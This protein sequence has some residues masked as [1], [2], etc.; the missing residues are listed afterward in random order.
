MRIGFIGTGNMGT[1]L[2]KGVVRSGI[3]EPGNIR[4]FDVDSERAAALCRETGVELAESNKAL[5]EWADY[6][7]LAVKPN[8]VKIPL[9][10]CKSSFDASKVLISIAAG[11]AIKSIKD[12]LGTDAKVVR[13]MPNMPAFVGEGMTLVSFDDKINAAEKGIVR[14]LFESSGKVEELEERLMNE[15]TALTGSSPAYVYIFLEAMGDAAVQLGIP[16]NK[17]YKL[18]AQAVLGSAK[19]VLESGMHPAELKD[20][21]CSPAGTTIEAVKTLEKHGFRYVIMDAIEECAKKA[22]EIGRSAAGDK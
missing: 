14:K 1:I 3:A 11:V 6:V 21:V 19:M 5:V 15:G 16:R 20:L 18:A 7:I 12:I 17:A 8:C 9:E 2:V 4:I 13:T 22:R 10:E